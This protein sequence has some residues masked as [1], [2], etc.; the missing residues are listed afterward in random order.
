MG[1]IDYSEGVIGGDWKLLLD[2]TDTQDNNWWFAKKE[3][4]K[5][6]E[7]V[8][9]CNYKNNQIWKDGGNVVLRSKTTGEQV[10]KVLNGSGSR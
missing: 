6:S 3:N 10:K 9:Q 8:Q 2:Y 4:P 7:C 5:N 1:Y